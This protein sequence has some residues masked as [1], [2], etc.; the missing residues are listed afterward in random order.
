MRQI[1]TKLLFA[2]LI[3]AGS[4]MTAQAEEDKRGNVMIVAGGCFWCVESDFDHVPGVLE[5]ISGYTGG[6]LADPSYKDMT[7]GKSGHL[8]VVAIKLDPNKVSYSQ[9]LDVFWRSVDP[10][11]DG[12]LFCDRGDSYATAI[13]A[14]TPEQKRLAEESKRKISTS[15]LLKRLIVTPVHDAGPFYRAEEYHQDYYKRN[16]LRYRLYRYNRGRDQRIAEIW[17]DEAHNGISTPLRS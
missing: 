12:C 4:A 9:L 2:F 11:D 17:G 3:A 1:F 13:F 7:G 5:T 16:P 15:G 8:E 10:T 14:T 6:H